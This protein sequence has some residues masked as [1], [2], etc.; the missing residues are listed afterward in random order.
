MVRYWLAEKSSKLLPCPLDVFLAS[1]EVPVVL[2]ALPS[3]PHFSKKLV[4]QLLEA[5]FVQ[6][7]QVWEA[8]YNGVEWQLAWMQLIEFASWDL[9]TCSAATAERET[10]LTFRLRQ[11][12][13]HVALT[14]QPPS[15]LSRN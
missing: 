14:E 1:F 15:F 2:V 11:Q 8:Q 10:A 13:D 12:M 4:S 7:W 9:Y 3:P 6:M 5:L